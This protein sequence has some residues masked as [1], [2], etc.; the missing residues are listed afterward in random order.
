MELVERARSLGALG[1]TISGAGPS[2]LVW[3]RSSEAAAVAQRL[4]SEVAGWAQVLR[5]P[6]ATGGAEVG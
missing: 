1:A 5:L 6:F 4:E 2:V 3:A